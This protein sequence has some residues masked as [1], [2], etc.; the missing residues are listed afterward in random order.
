MTTQDVLNV[1]STVALSLGGGG[2]LVLALSSW[3]GKVWASR[4]LEAEKNRY[5][6][7]IESIRNNYTRDIESLKA[8]L[9]RRQFDFQTRFSFYYQQRAESIMKLYG[10]LD[11]AASRL[12]DLV[13]PV[14]SSDEAA[15]LARFQAAQDAYNA[16]AEAFFTRK[17]FFEE[18]ICV[19]IES[20]LK[21]M[22]TAFSAFRVSQNSGPD[23]SVSQEL[24]H[25]A[26]QVMKD[27]VPPLLKQLETAFRNSLLVPTPSDAQ[28][29]VA[30]D[31][32]QQV[33]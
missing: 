31:E 28:L 9:A 11:M 30:P 12:S 7:E 15:A 2:A 1:I 33:L 32:A 21:S 14:Q 5:A 3:L 17:I 23:G 22:R 13:N 24:W 10:A 18:A 20:V 26:Y 27:E 19:S 8:D 25:K 16:A 6:R 4:I 29:A